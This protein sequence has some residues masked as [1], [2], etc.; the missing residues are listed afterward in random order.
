MDEFV[1]MGEFS[2]MHEFVIMGKFSIIGEFLHVLW[3]FGNIPM[4]F[5]KRGSTPCI[6]CKQ[7]KWVIEVSSYHCPMFL[8]A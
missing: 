1:V 5:H 7:K 6:L 3:F 4:Y 8:P 2:N